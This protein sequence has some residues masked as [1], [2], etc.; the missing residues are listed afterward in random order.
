MNLRNIDE[1]QQFKR[2]AATEAELMK[3][4][5]DTNLKRHKELPIEFIKFESGGIKNLEE[6]QQLTGN[7]LLK[8][9]VADDIKSQQL[10]RLSNKKIYDDLLSLLRELYDHGTVVLDQINVMRNNLRPPVQQQQGLTAARIQRFH[11]FP[12]DESVAG[13]LCS[14]CRDDVEIGRSMMR[15]DC[16]GQHVFCQ[17]CVEGWFAA[18]NTC[19]YC[20]HVFI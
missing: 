12:A 9:V 15:L 17:G 18:H 2:R 3:E 10:L 7:W 19:P 11:Q 14:I 1:L 20:N 4:R 8:Q 16:N 5:I 13:D 6:F